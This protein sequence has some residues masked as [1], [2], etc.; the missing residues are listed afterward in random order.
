MCEVLLGNQRYIMH[1]PTLQSSWGKRETNVYIIVKTQDKIR[2]VQ[3][4]DIVEACMEEETFQ[5]NPEGRS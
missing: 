5:Y 4:G 3:E 2:A 1:D